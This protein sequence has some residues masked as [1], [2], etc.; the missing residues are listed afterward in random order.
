[1]ISNAAPAKRATQLDIAKALLAKNFPELE[2]A[3][4]ASASSPA[5]PIV[6]SVA[7]PKMRAIELMKMRH[8]ATPGDPKDMA[9]SV[10]M[11][12][13]VHIHV[14]SNTV[15]TPVLLWFRKASQ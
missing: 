9:S 3:K 4:L 11:D 2:V 15:Q 7:K 10:P 1:M 8:K 13:R 6:K 12:R 5:S 14:S